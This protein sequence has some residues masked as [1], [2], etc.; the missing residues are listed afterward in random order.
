M[1]LLWFLSTEFTPESAWREELGSLT[2][3][4]SA[5]GR[6]PAVRGSNLWASED[7]HVDCFMLGLRQPR[8]EL[9]YMFSWATEKGWQLVTG[10]A[11]VLSDSLSV[12]VWDHRVTGSWFWLTHWKKCLGCM[13]T[14]Q[15][16]AK[17]GTG[18]VHGGYA[19]LLCAVHS[20]LNILLAF[21]NAHCGPLTW[22]HFWLMDC[23]C[24]VMSL[25]KNGVSLVFFKRAFIGIIRRENKLFENIVP[26]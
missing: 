6:V 3:A 9:W 17:R 7:W 19:P 4:L 21:L 5:L 10:S 25:T 24:E 12:T 2:P 26:P 18:L 14:Y 22:F 11:Q 15:G 8:A 16:R 23:N 20:F 13:C 1:E